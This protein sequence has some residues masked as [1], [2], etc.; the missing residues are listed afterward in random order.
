[1]KVVEF[2][3]ISRAGKTTQIRDLAAFLGENYSVSVFERPNINFRDMRGMDEF[4]NVLLDSMINAYEGALSRGDDFLLYDRG[5]YD[6][7]VM[8]A[9]DQSEGLISDSLKG[10][11][12]EKVELYMAE[13]THP[14]LFIIPPS[15]SI[16]RMSAQR[17][18]G[19]DN[20]R[21]TNGLKTRDSYEGI[22]ELIDDYRSLRKDYP[23]IVQVGNGHSI[24]ETTRLIRSILGVESCTK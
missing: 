4:H 3:G 22:A 17:R 8:V 24:E 16:D 14:F 9:K 19:L 12:G 23:K 5:F 1:M 13:V 20:S 10:D 15:V 18:E 21:L 7:R 6:R 2:F 11:L